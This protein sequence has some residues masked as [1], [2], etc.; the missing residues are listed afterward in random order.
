M[1]LNL[2]NIFISK[3]IYFFTINCATNA[4][5]EL[6][7]YCTFMSLTNKIKI[8]LFIHECSLKIRPQ[9]R[10]NFYTVKFVKLFLQKILFFCSFF[11]FAN[12]ATNVGVLIHCYNE[13]GLSHYKMIT[14]VKLLK[15][16]TKLTNYMDQKFCL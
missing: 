8:T 9:C 13:R 7:F 15:Y 2:L 6:S 14:I 5:I 1:C 3:L 12:E 11:L 10:S 4:C 16:V